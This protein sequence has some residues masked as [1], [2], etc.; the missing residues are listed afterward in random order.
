MSVKTL[1]FVPLFP[2]GETLHRDGMSGPRNAAVPASADNS[3]VGPCLPATKKRYRAGLLWP[4]TAPLLGA[5]LA[6]ISAPTCICQRAGSIRTDRVYI[7]GR[8]GR[9]R[10]R[11]TAGVSRARRC[12]TPLTRPAR[13]RSTAPDGAQ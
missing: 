3:E 7:S 1:S 12:R 11:A 8:E 13:Y 5:A 10:A 4:G 9:W 6:R 2:L